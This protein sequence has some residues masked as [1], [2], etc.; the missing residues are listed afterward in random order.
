MKIYTVFCKCPTPLA[1]NPYV[2]LAKNEK[3]AKDRFF[4]RN[5]ISGSDHPI[6]IVEGNVQELPVDE[7]ETE[8]DN[9]KTPAELAAEYLAS[10]PEATNK[11]V[12]AAL[13]ELGA[14][15]TS[16][17]VTAVKRQLSEA[18]K[19]ERSDNAGDDQE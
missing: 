18:K 1:A 9:V 17:E 6:E 5:G 10:K 15:I 13:K 8:V 7:A 4:L 12:I 14:E 2:T 11:E 16:P 3:I 19:D